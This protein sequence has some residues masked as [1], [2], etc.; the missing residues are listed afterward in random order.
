MDW[1]LFSLKV[2]SEVARQKNFTKA[3]KILG[4]TQPAVSLQ[5]QNLERQLGAPLLIRKRT[6]EMALTEAGQVVLRYM[7]NI[8]R[9][10]QNLQRDLEPWT[11]ARNQVAIG[12]CC[13]AGEHIVPSYTVAFRRL[14]PHTVVQCHVGRCVDIFGRV[15]DG[16]LDVAIAGIPPRDPRLVHLPFVHMPLACFEAPRDSSPRRLSIK[17]LVSEPVVLRE[18]G[19]G[20]RVALERFLKQHDLALDRCAIVATSESNEALKEMVAKGMGWSILPNV[21]I[22]KELD[23]G[24]LRLIELAEGCPVQDFFVVYRKHALLNGPQKEFVHLLMQEPRPQYAP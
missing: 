2:F 20:T 21:V 10:F 24:R 4:L 9:V 22:Q 16:S 5:V 3:A 13:I 15:L 18:E 17:D 8:E 14:R 7:E 1:N 19:S 23:Q 11:S 12:C 6:G